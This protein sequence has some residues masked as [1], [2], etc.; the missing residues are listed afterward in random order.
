MFTKRVA[1]HD[2]V[3]QVLWKH[4]LDPRAPQRSAGAKVRASYSLKGQQGMCLR[5]EE[6]RVSRQ[7]ERCAR[8]QWPRKSVLSSGELGESKRSASRKQQ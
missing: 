2:R 1:Q 4:R 7:R 5:P 3:Q 8:H 6:G